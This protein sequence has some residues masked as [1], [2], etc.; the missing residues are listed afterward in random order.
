MRLRS[1]VWPLLS[2]VVGVAIGFPLSVL[3]ARWLGP[4]GKGELSLV[5]LLTELGGLCLAFGAPTAFAYLTARGRL[6]GRRSVLYSYTMAIVA[7]FVAGLAALLLAGAVSRSLFKTSDPF[8]LIMGTVGIGISVVAQTLNS[9]MV[10]RG[11]VRPAAIVNAAS[12]VVQ[13][14]VF[15]ALALVGLL[16]TKLAVW[17]WIAVIAGVAIVFTALEWSQRA[18]GPGSKPDEIGSTLR[19][20]AAAWTMAIAGYLLLRQD[21]LVVSALLGPGAV[22]VYGIA[23]TFAQ[24]AMFVPN[25]LGAILMPKVAGEQDAGA[26][27][28][29]VS[30]LVWPMAVAV[31]AA[32]AAVAVPV[33]PLVFGQPFAGAVGPLVALVPAMG[34]YAL[35]LAVQAYLVGVGRPGDALAAVVAGVSVNLIANVI[36]LSRIGITGA[37]LASVAGYGVAAAVAVALFSRH[38]GISVADVVVPR[39][40]DVRAA[41]AAFRGGGR[42]DVV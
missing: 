17:T 9:A 26:V 22:G 8:L 12:P 39:V 27:V 21:M 24:V 30:R 40:S 35:L 36:L 16:N 14:V 7:W 25:A 2:Q 4:V 20:G 10:G 31:A 11:R 3:L 23:V 37:G 34:A 18:D 41:V 5:Q 19:F 38:A 13:I 42:G 33:I 28:A 32:V 6:D 1:A 15:A 29:R